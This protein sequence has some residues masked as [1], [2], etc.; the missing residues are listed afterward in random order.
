[1]AGSKY[2]R[3]ETANRV[4]TSHTCFIPLVLNPVSYPCFMPLVYNYVV[5]CV[6]VRPCLIVRTLQRS[7]VFCCASLT[8]VSMIACVC[9]CACC[10]WMSNDKRRDRERERREK[11]E[12]QRDREAERQR[13]RETERQRD[14][15]TERN[16]DVS[17]REPSTRAHPRSRMH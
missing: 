10:M 1:M 7:A 6:V 14:R 5:L 17:T 11:T 9:V 2:E 8:C 16:G 15:E 4:Y 13:E 12:R 3:H